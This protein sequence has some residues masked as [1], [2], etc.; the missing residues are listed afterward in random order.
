MPIDLGLGRSRTHSFALL[1]LAFA[2]LGLELLEFQAV[3]FFLVA[4]LLFQLQLL[5]RLDANLLRLAVRVAIQECLTST[6]FVTGNLLLES[7]AGAENANLLA[8][9]FGI[10]A[11]ACVADG[12]AAMS[13]RILKK[14][15]SL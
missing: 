8:A 6:V 7:L 12:C 11:L 13:A 9:Q 1:V 15:I 3:S 10:W 14:C 2:E 5:C 4:T